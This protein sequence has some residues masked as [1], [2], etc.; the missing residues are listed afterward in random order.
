MKKIILSLAWLIIISAAT[1][2]ADEIRPFHKDYGF[3]NSYEQLREII[4]LSAKLENSR[5]TKNYLKYKFKTDPV[6]ELAVCPHDDYAYA[7]RVYTHVIPYI[8]AK[9]IIIFGVAHKARD[10]GIKD[11]LI[12]GSFKGWDTWAGVLPV[13]GFRDKFTHRLGKDAGTNN[14][15]MIKEHSIEAL[16]HWIRHLHTDAEIIPICVPYMNWEKMNEL[17]DKFSDILGNLMREKGLSF[18]KD[19]MILASNDSSHYG[20]QGWGGKNYAPFGCDVTGYTRGTDRDLNLSKDYLEGNIQTERIKSF[21]HSL[22][23]EDKVE[24]YLITWCG[25][26]SVPFSILVYNKTCAQMDRN[27]GRGK[28]LRYGTSVGEGIPEPLSSP[29]EVT[30]PANL[31]H[32][33]GYI[34]LGFNRQ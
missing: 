14:E 33:V 19:I 30:A 28:F 24:E 15:F 2:P 22:V 16:A 10:Y 4:E 6:W 3:A 29:A 34:A 25:R 32:W 17:T 11:R 7:G 13:S 9:T 27:P 5:I 1:L 12:F 18:G 26:F 23:N 8:K 21:F 20:D 31:H